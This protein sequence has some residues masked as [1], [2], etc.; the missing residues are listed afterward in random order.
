MVTCKFCL[1]LVEHSTSADAMD[2]MSCLPPTPVRVFRVFHAVQFNQSESRAHSRRTTS[3][4]APAQAAPFTNREAKNRPKSIDASSVPRD[5]RREASDHSRASTSES[6]SPS[7]TPQ[8]GSLPPG[9]FMTVTL[10]KTNSV[11][12]SDFQG[13]HTLTTPHHSV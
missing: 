9:S 11:Y 10:C 1:L 4:I 5:C 6:R 7:G 8:P 2:C 3:S 13:T 12:A